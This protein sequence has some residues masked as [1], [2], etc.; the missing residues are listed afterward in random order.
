MFTLKLKKV[1]SFIISAVFFSMLVFFYQNDAKAQCQTGY[2]PRAIYMNVNGCTYLV[3][4][5]VKCGNGP[6]PGEVILMDFSKIETTPPCEQTWNAQQILNYINNHIRTFDFINT[7]LCLNVVAPPCQQGQGPIYT[8]R[9][10]LCY[11]IEK[12]SYFG[13][14]RIVYR[15]CDY[16]NYCEESFKYCFD[17][18]PP[19]GRVTATR[20]SGPTLVGSITCGLGAEGVY[21]PTEYNVPTPCYIYH[22]PCN[23]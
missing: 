19:H 4:M 18:I 12:I 9:H 17:P 22:T 11:Y 8:F 16:D 10:W 21:E 5:C 15:P 14:D 13:E 2:T 3:N 1:G 23:P 6:V 20:V 7:Y